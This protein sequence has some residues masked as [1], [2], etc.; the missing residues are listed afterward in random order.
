M[1]K[2]VAR[3]LAD[4]LIFITDFSLN[5]AMNAH[6]VRTGLHGMINVKYHIAYQGIRSIDTIIANIRLLSSVVPYYICVKIAIL[7]FK[8]FFI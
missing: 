8:S 2:S 3:L 1:Q 4:K 7:V 6:T 5:R